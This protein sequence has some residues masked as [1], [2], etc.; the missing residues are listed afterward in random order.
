MLDSRSRMTLQDDLSGHGRRTNADEEL[1]SG[2]YVV[3]PDRTFGRPYRRHLGR[4]R[5]KM[6]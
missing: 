6:P 5:G 3:V 1:K 4:L 2:E